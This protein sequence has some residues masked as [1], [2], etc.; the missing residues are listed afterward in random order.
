MRNLK[1]FSCL[2]LAVIFCLFASVPAQASGV[3]SLTLYA[4]WQ[5]DVTFDANGGILTDGATDAERAIAGQESGVIR[6]T[7]GI[8]AA[9]GLSADREGHEFVAWNTRPDGTGTDIADY[10]VITGPV[11]F[12]A[13]YY[14]R[15]Y[16]CI[17]DYQTFTAP[18][19]GVYTLTAQGGRGGGGYNGSTAGIRGAVTQADI[20]L[21]AGDVL[22][23]YVGGE[24]G[25]AYPWTGGASGGWNGGG[26]TGANNYNNPAHNHGGGG[27][28]TDFRL[29]SGAWNDSESLSSRIMV[30]A[31]GGG[32]GAHGTGGYG[33]TTQGQGGFGQGNPNLCG[34]YGATL[35]AGGQ[36]GGGFGY[37]GN[38]GQ[39]GGGGGGGYYGGGV[40]W[41]SGAGGGSSYIAGFDVCPEHYSGVEFMNC[42][43][44]ANAGPSGSGF[45]RILLK[46]LD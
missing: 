22:Y 15:D 2:L 6:I 28:A 21:N 35:T 4:Q 30:A 31:G 27:G 36:P 44:S 13:T 32:Y 24:G 5:A 34:G 14:Q 7:T 45:A 33:G 29:V 39:N 16:Y 17:G 1:R 11:T 43:W 9:T 10:G 42:S 26:S 18:L 19:S 38:G 25:I 46:T 23:V 12:Y 20:H 40:A 37:G 3:N 41:Y 8:T